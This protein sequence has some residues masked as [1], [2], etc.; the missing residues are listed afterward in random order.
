MRGIIPP[1][2]HESEFTRPK[3]YHGM[4]CDRLL[5]GQVTVHIDDVVLDTGLV[6]TVSAVLITPRI[7]CGLQGL[8]RLEA[9]VVI[10]QLILQG[11]VQPLD[12]PRRG[13]RSGPGEPL[14]CGAMR[15]PG[16]WPE[17]GP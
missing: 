8:D 5:E 6:R 14:S 15:S 11:L 17:A 7:Q 16:G 4:F 2:S 10:E 13:R 9:A 12:L 1:R 3:Y